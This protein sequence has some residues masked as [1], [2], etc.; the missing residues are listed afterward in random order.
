MEIPEHKNWE[1][2]AAAGKAGTEF[3][4]VVGENGIPTG[5]IVS[6]EKA[7]ADGI[8]HRTSH[9]WLLRR[10]DEKIQLLLQKRCAQKDSWPGC[11]DTSSAGHIP[12]G[13]DFIASAIR[14]LQ[15]ELGV[16]AAP[17]AL[18]FCGDRSV[19]DD[20]D[21]H[22][23][24]FHDR[25]Y[26]RVFILWHDQ[27]AYDF[28]LQREEIDSVRWMKLDACIEAVRNNTMKHCI[29]LE[30]LNMVKAAV[31]RDICKTCKRENARYIT[32]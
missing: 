31:D 26:S 28:V 8:R 1:P 29:S 17:E 18:I 25:Q 5:Q 30:E 10:R 4:D 27:E 23:R 7:H 20:G 3:L 13:M 24:P 2:P 22:G 9:V 6:R 21:F 16:N 15:E 12:A 11:Y 19:C 14:E 32:R